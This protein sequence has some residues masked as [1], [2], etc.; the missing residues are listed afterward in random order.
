MWASKFPSNYFENKE[1]EISIV[2]NAIHNLSRTRLGKDLSSL[3]SS[4]TT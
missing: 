1:R 2:R 4:S 3:F